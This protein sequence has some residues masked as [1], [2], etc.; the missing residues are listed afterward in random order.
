MPLT[1]VKNNLLGD[2]DRSSHNQLIEPLRDVAGYKWSE[3]P[4]EYKFDCIR[5][6][7]FSQH[8]A[9]N[10]LII[11]L[12]KSEVDAWINIAKERRWNWKVIEDYRNVTVRDIMPDNTVFP[13]I[14]T[15]SY[16]YGFRYMKEFQNLH[17]GLVMSIRMSFKVTGNKITQL[18]SMREA[19]Q[20]FGCRLEDI[21]IMPPTFYITERED[22]LS[23]FKYAKKGLRWVLKPSIGY[24][25]SGITLHDDLEEIKKLFG[26]CQGRPDNVEED[27]VIQQYI[28]NLLLLNG[29]KFDI[30]AVVLIASTTPF[31]MFFHEGFLRV[32]TELFSEDSTDRRVHFTNTHV[33]Q[34]VANASIN[35]HLWSFDRFQKYIEEFHPQRK[36]FVERE[37]VPFIKNVGRLIL[38]AGKIKGLHCATDQSKPS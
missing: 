13:I 15:L 30:R 36:D 10:V 16:V 20:Q 14:Y 35:D 18:I 8:L 33:Q 7:R 6:P 17:T 9:N 12:G 31:L 19:F 25:G 21:S 37:L 2:I 3:I 24:G 11:F 22:C 23:F 34:E 1:V 38:R 28:P 32:S 5:I 4:A 29:F 27:C 26:Q